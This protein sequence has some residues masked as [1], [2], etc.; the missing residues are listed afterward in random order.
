M[1]CSHPTLFNH[2]SARY[3]LL[4]MLAGGETAGPFDPACSLWLGIDNTAEVAVV[5]KVSCMH[6][7]RYTGGIGLFG[8]RGGWAVHS[9]YSM[10]I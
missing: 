6:Y 10:E 4:H 2:I 5:L 7:W 9:K 3:T 8:F 1:S